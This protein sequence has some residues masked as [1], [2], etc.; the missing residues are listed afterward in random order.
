MLQRLLAGTVTLIKEA[1]AGHVRML[2]LIKVTPNCSRL[3]VA[4]TAGR[5]YGHSLLI[6]S[7]AAY[8][9]DAWLQ[10]TGPLLLLLAAPKACLG[11]LSF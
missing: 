2:A 9:V 3:P 4:D 7:L 8:P 11:V 5:P 6:I 10:V 1:R